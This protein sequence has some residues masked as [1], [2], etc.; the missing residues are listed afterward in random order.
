MACKVHDS[1]CTANTA[2]CEPCSNLLKV[3]VD[4]CKAGVTSAAARSS[5][6][7]FQRLSISVPALRPLGASLLLSVFPVTKT[8]DELWDSTKRMHELEGLASW[9]KQ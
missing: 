5:F 4:V 3:V 8:S 9:T 6:C 7:R 2:L 1:H